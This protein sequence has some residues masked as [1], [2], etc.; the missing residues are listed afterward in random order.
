MNYIVYSIEE[1]RERIRQSKEYR[2]WAKANRISSR[3]EGDSIEAYRERY[4][5]WLNS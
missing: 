5:Q 1:T 3:V 4:T 2:R